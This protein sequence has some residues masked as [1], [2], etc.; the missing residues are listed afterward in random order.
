MWG[1]ASHVSCLLQQ[2]VQRMVRELLPIDETVS[3]GSCDDR[4][5]CGGGCQNSN[6][7]SRIKIRQL[8]IQCNAFNNEMWCVK[9]NCIRLFFILEGYNKF[10]PELN[11]KNKHFYLILIILR[12]VL[13]THNTV[14]HK[15]FTVE[16][17]CQVNK[18]NTIN[19]WL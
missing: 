15:Y 7:I 8:T 18:N 1:C 6:W 11:K 4:W 13:I 3:G 10:V 19:F 2:L 9:I 12:H 5:I 16:H 17:N 14:L